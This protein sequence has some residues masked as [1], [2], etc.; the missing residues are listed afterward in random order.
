MVQARHAEQHHFN[1][2]KARTFLHLKNNQHSDKNKSPFETRTVCIIPIF[3]MTKR[4][5]S[6]SPYNVA[7]LGPAGCDN[8]DCSHSIF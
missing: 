5:Q 4:D 2:H 6:G 3:P 7:I 1:G 8:F